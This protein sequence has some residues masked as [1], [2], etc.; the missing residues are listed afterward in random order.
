MTRPV[1]LDSSAIVALVVDAGP[2]GEWVASAMHDGFLAAPALALFEAANTLRRQQLAGRLEQVE[3]LLAHHALLD[4]PL[5]LW[6]YPP[7][8]ERAWAL[9]D[10][11]TIYDAA[12]V[13]LAE[14]LDAR[15]VTLD[16]RLARA[17]GPSCVIVTPPHEAPQED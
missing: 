15:L 14:L 7:L 2:V 3:A 9:R 12:Y 10:S 11:I 17:N 8:A 13:A 1:V 16:R 4:L 5:Q 6:P